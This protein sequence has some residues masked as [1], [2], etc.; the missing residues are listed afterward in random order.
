[1]QPGLGAQMLS[2]RH[3]P[4]GKLLQPPCPSAQVAL[5]DFPISLKKPVGLSIG[6]CIQQLDTLVLDFTNVSLVLEVLFRELCAWTV[7]D[8]DSVQQGVSGISEWDEHSQNRQSLRDDDVDP[9]L[10]SGVGLRPDLQ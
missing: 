9:E 7:V 10:Q 1:M 4:D 6:L 8:D 2:R 3:D 5:K